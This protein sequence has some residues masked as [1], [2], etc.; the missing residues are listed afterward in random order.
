MNSRERFLT[1]LHGGT[2]DRTPLAH[3]AAL[4]TVELQT[5]TGCTMPDVHH[6]A[7]E[8]ARLLA[9]NHE[10]LGFDAVSFIINYFGEPAALGVQMDWGGPAQLP[11]F[12]SHPWRDAEDAVIPKDLLS[13][14]PIDTYIETIRIARGN[15]DD[16][17]VLGKVMGPFSVAQVMHGI[18]NVLMALIDDPG[19][20]ARFIDVCVDILVA[21][22]NAQFDAGADAVS[23]GEGGAG[24]KMLSPAMY[25]R[26]LL[27]A[28]QR[29]IDR[30][31][32][33]TIMHIC[34][35]VRSRLPMI[36]QTGLTC[37]NF[38]WDI[39]PAEMVAAA[40]AGTYTV[41]GNVN[42]TDLLSGKPAEIQ[43][44]VVA[45][46]DAGVNIISPGCAVS[47]K[48]PNENLHAM[49]DAIAR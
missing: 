10:V 2:P 35:D 14:H 19:K 30:I 20:I 45:A 44:Q 33:P 24:A 28:H 42:T 48:C 8:Q 18:D 39:P 23:I 31:N 7:A 34:G 5:F 15:H 16:V 9:A 3:V 43:R 25:E 46:I 17:A 26:F 40:A 4:T 11:V 32:G 1:A 47:P 13:R 37:F 22:A 21:C 29:M 12:R 27:P 38:D 36:A 41:M 49:A 6:D